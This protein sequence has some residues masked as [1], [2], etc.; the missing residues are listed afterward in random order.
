MKYKDLTQKL[1]NAGYTFLRH[2][3]NHDVYAKGNHKV[4]VPRHKEIKEYTAR[5]ILK[6]CGIK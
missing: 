1:L 2:G 5:G 4:A 6:E 3:G